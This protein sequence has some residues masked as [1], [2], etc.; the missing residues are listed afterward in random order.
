MEDKNQ[1]GLTVRVRQEGPIPLNAELVCAPGEFL[2]LVGP[3]GSG[4][5]TVLCSIAGLYRPKQGEIRCNGEVW[6]D[7]TRNIHASPQHRSVGF[8]FQN[9]ALFPHMT[10]LQNV[11]AAL[12]HLPRPRRE[13]RSRELLDLVHLT[14]LESRFPAMLSGGQQ[15]R[16]AVARALARDPKVLLLDEP[17]SAVDKVTRQKL[18]RELA[19][20]RQQLRMP[21]VLVTHDL[22][23]AAMLSDRMCILHRGTTL[24]SGP[25][26]E[27]MAH[28]RDGLVAR[29]VDVKNV[30][31]GRI[32]KHLPERGL[33]VLSWLN[34]TLEARLNQAFPDGSA[35]CW[36]IP[37]ANVILHRRDRPSRGEHENPVQ[38]VISEF[39]RLGE[40]TSVTI[41]INGSASLPLFLSVP[42]HVANRNR[43]GLGEP[44]TVSLLAD[45][46]HLMPWQAMQEQTTRPEN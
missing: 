6:L 30:F 45:A 43:L 23:E 2:T 35:V 39:I 5:S 11:M 15:Q 42:T 3:S 1:G 33:T 19:E 21:V 24:Q 10:A 17:F 18:Y 20:L 37:T 34:Y 9:Y 4:K 41:R 16:V 29:L 38:G 22:D 44:I 14:G 27:V 40:N 31:E 36:T 32:S 8:V 28:P 25:P 7:T 46:I 13:P 12:G 26:F